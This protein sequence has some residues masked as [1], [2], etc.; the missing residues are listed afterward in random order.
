MTDRTVDDD[1]DMLP[2]TQDEDVSDAGN[3]MAL[4]R[5]VVESL[6]GGLE[7]R[8]GKLIWKFAKPYGERL[9]NLLEN[10]LTVKTGLG[11]SQP[12]PALET[13]RNNLNTPEFHAI[14]T[15][16]LS[17]ALKR[18]EFRKEVQRLLHE[19]KG[20]PAAAGVVQQVNAGDHNKITQIVGHFQGDLNLPT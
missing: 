14:L 5:R 2:S 10:R 3:G 16:A 19:E 7:A 15:V 9:W 1:G 12:S 13:F 4:A 18:E 8:A 6:V 20:G 11:E 17:E